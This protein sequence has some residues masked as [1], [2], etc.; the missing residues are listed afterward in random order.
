MASYPRFLLAFIL[1][2]FTI[3]KEKIYLFITHGSC[4]NVSCCGPAVG[5]GGGS[6]VIDVFFFLLSQGHTALLPN[7]YSFSFPV[8]V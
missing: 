5:G 2:S 7:F 1:C 6:R 8:F 3:F 4:I